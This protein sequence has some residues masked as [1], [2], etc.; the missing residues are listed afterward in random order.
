M[1]HWLIQFLSVYPDLEKGIPPSK[2]L[3]TLEL[4]WFETLKTVKWRRDYILER[5]TA[6]H[7]LQSMLQIEEEIEVPLQELTIFNDANGAPYVT[8]HSEGEVRYLPISLSISHHDC[9][10]FCAATPLLSPLFSEAGMDALQVQPR[11]CSVG[12]NIEPIK[13]HSAGFA[14]SYFTDN[15]SELVARTPLADGRRDLL[16]AAIWSAKG[17]IDRA[18][19]LNATIDMEAVSCLV[20]PQAVHP[21]A[22]TPFEIL[23]ESHRLNT[24]PEL[25]LGWWKTIERFVLTMVVSCTNCEKPLTMTN[26]SDSSS[27]TRQALSRMVPLVN[28]SILFRNIYPCKP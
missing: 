1:L 24:P 13:Q 8:W 4:D 14:A 23:W 9:C 10:A 16:T 12:V 15:E 26:L 5:W 17:A 22:W 19:H 25:L 7:L 28:E 2:L 27:L 6:K 18:L 11:T 3:N 21:S 20:E